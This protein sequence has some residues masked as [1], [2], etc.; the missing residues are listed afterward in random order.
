MDFGLE[1]GMNSALDSLDSEETEWSQDGLEFG[2]LCSG[3]L[4]S[5]GRF[6][7]ADLQKSRKGRFVIVV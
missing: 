6:K 3:P 7:S 4:S 1:S 5:C 2:G